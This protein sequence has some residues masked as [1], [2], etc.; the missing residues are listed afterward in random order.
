EIAPSEQLAIRM[1]Q[2]RLFEAD[3]QTDRAI[4]V[5]QAVARA[6]LDK[7]A[8]PAQL[9]ASRLLLAK[10][11]ITPA[12]T[13]ATLEPL[14]YRWRGDATE[15]AVIRTLG[16]V[17]LDQ[18]RYREALD[19]LRGAGARYPDLPESVALNEQLQN[20]FRALF[21]DGQADGLQ[22]IQAVAL[23]LDFRDL[24]PVGADGDEMVRRLARRLVDVDLLDQ[25]ADMLKYQ[26][27]NRL[28]GVA[29]ASVATDLARIYLMSR[30][31]EQALQAIW[32]SRTTLLP[33]ALNSE[34]RAIEARALSDL[35]RFDN[36][37][38]VLGSDAGGQADDVRGEIAWKQQRWADAAALYERRL[39]DRWKNAVDPLSVE[40][41]SRLVRAG[42]GYSLAQ[43]AGGLGRLSQRYG[44]FADRARAPAAVRIALAGPDESSISVRDITRVA[45]QVDAFA[46]WVASQKQRF[47]QRTDATR[48]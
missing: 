29:K 38:E 30:K 21:L 16:Q 42:V 8:T 13:I 28:E 46:G 17:Y 45:G 26:V 20:A 2:A 37:L 31:P 9:H 24:T 44:V 48:T 41:E 34:R 5:Y 3:G 4:A 23:F 14:R 18:G 22:P 12:Q 47:R 43:D 27:E 6:P 33:N 19:A 32:G 11:A 40:D 7:L 25:A 39:G 36:A 35:G 10:G 1:V 15:L